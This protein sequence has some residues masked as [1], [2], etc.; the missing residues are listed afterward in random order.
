VG[1]AAHIAPGTA[2]AVRLP[3]SATEA[4]REALVLRERSGAL[5]AYRNRCKHLPIPLD[6]GGGRFLDA[7]GNVR[8]A[9]HGALYAP[10]TGLCFHGPC[11]GASLDPLALEVDVDGDLYVCDDGG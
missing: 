4:R 10:D 2:V 6:A 1:A 7:R 11:R 3:S 9:T 5:R 8:C